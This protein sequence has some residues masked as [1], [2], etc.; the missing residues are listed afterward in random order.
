VHVGR[1]VEEVLPLL[2][3]RLA[4]TE[5]PKRRA[6]GGV[7]EFVELTQAQRIG[8]GIVDGLH[9]CRVQGQ[10]GWRQKHHQA[11]YSDGMLAN[12]GSGG[13]TER[14]TC[15]IPHGETTLCQSRRSAVS[16]LRVCRAFAAMLTLHCKD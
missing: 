8:V 10:S 11:R 14:P 2:Q 1:Q 5:H 15:Q 12:P 16:A 3:L 6:F 13:V 4:A 7:I 9:V